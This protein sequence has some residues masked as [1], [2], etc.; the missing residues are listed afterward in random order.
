MFDIMFLF[1]A[2]L[3]MVQG[4]NIVVKVNKYQESNT[5]WKN[6]FCSLNHH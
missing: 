1:N 6:I 2:A 3:T 4:G 5:K